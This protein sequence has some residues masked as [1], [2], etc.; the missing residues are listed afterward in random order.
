MEQEKIR[1]WNIAKRLFGFFGTLL[2][3]YLCLKFATYFMPFFIAGLLAIIIE[4]II[5]FN[6]NKLRMSRRMSSI[7]VVLCTILLII[8]L[9]VWG[10]SAAISKLIEISKTLPGTLSYVSTH[11]Q[12]VINNY[13]S[14]YGD[15]VSPDTI[16]T[17]SSSITN[18]INNLGGYLQSGITTILQVVLSVPRMIVNVV[19]TILALVFFTKDRVFMIDMLEYHV[20]EKWL[21]KVYKVKKELFTTIGNYLKVYSKILFITFIELLIAFAILNL[22]GFQIDHFIRLAFV[23][24]IIDILPILGVGT[25]LIPW[26]VWCF[27]S[28][29]VPFGI[30]LLIVYLTILIIRQFIEPKLVSD[31]LGVHPIITLLA[32]WAGFRMIGF[33]G[34]ILGP[35]ALMILRCVYADQIKKGLFKSLVEEEK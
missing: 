23:I 5:K 11:V 15:Q 3:L 1:A 27:I 32:M 14:E 13:A 30:A 18:F 12:E 19:I 34:L 20:P 9:V 4:P 24:A 28:G 6:M 31:Q 17:V 26:F 10:S 35:I 29:N 8:G 33:S 25:V 2:V 21:L 22:I 7:I 16:D